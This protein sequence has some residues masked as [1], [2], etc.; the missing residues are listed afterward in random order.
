M[1][2]IARPS[3]LE[4]SSI[5]SIVLCDNEN[6]TNFYNTNHNQY[7]K[8]SF[9]YK[10][11]YVVDQLDLTPSEFFVYYTIRKTLSDEQHQTSL[12]ENDVVSMTTL[13]AS[14]ISK[15][16]RSLSVKREDLG[17]KSLILLE[18]INVAPDTPFRIFLTDISNENISFVLNKVKK[19]NS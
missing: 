13:S 16:L 11:P 8:S 12:Y 4:Q 15:I 9:Y 5:S 14:K 1:S 18:R 19:E 17:G 7:V 2:S 3:D 10:I 6:F